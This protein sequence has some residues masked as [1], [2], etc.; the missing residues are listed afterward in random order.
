MKEQVHIDCRYFLGDRPCKPHKL[1]GVHCRDCQYF[2]KVKTRILIIKLGAA[3][4]VIR[5]TPILRR[6]RKEFPDSSV[7]WLTDQIQFVP[8]EVD[9]KLEYS[10][11]S[12]PWIYTRAFDLCINLDKEKEAIALCESVK[13]SKKCGFGMDEFG[14]AKPLDAR[15][16]DKFLT[17]IFDDISKRN[18]KS[19][20]QEIFD[21]C[22]YTFEG[23]EYIVDNHST[24]HWEFGDGKG[25]VVGLNTGCG[26]RWPSRLWPVS[27]WCELAE[28]VRLAGMRYVWLGGPDEEQKN[29]ELQAKAGGAYFGTLPI[30]EFTGLVNAC[31]IVVTQVTMAL[32]LAIGLKKKVV[33][34]NNIFNKNEF[35]LYGRGVIIEPD[36]SCGCYY[37]PDCPHGSMNSILP[38]K[39][40]AAVQKVV[41]VKETDSKA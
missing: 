16:E 4:D 39:A 28:K 35:E 36:I 29:K 3:G 22:G 5:S 20:V 40:F 41:G 25:S 32:H 19:Y 6:L 11:R 31:D 17:G 7:T 33:L 21:I 18:M 27:Y 24:A 1:Y 23:E 8:D 10:A 2:E 15:A 9:E 26:R 12:I 30:R 34:M 14:K 13:A 37:S 38:E